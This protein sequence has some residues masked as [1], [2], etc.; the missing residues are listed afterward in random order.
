MLSVNDLFYLSS[1][2]IKHLFFE[3]VTSWL[4]ASNV[5]YISRVKF[6]GKSGLDHMFD[7]VIPKSEQYPERLVQAINQPSKD[8]AQIAVFKWM[9]TGNDRPQDVKLLTLLNDT[10]KPTNLSVIETFHNYNLKTILWSEREQSRDLFI[11]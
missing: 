1:S 5:R 6:T 4:S 10:T 3:D 8:T 2:Y 11:A 7:F 9:D